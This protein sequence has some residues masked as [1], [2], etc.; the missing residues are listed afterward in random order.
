MVGKKL[1]RGVVWK[2]VGIIND[3]I[4]VFNG[5]KKNYCLDVKCSVMFCFTFFVKF[6]QFLLIE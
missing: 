6:V 5:M 1:E 3:M 4:N 2:N